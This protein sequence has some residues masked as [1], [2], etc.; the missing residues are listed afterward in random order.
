MDIYGG[1]GSIVES[2]AALLASHG[3]IAYTLPYAGY[4]DLD[5]GSLEDNLLEYLVEALIYFQSLDSVLPGIAM[6]GLSFGATLSL[7]LS[8]MMPNIISNVVTIGGVHYFSGMIKYKGEYL[9]PPEI[10]PSFIVSTEVLMEKEVLLVYD[11]DLCENVT[12]KL[13]KAEKVKFLFIVGEDDLT[14]NS[15]KSHEILLNRMKRFGKED[16]MCVLKYPNAGHFIDP[17]Y[18]PQTLNGIYYYVI[19]KVIEWWE[20]C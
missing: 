14:V 20:M 4:D 13:E 6:V 8:T 5:L 10:T 2:R 18:M 16:Q 1:A 19:Q 15:V 9:I 11:D 7:Q 3:F 17:P 12:H